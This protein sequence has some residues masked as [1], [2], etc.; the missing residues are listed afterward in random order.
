MKHIKRFKSQACLLYYLDTQRKPQLSQDYRF[1]VE[2]LESKYNNQLNINC[3]HQY[4]EVM[5]VYQIEL[6]SY[7]GIISILHLQ[8][9]LLPKTNSMKERY[10]ICS[11][12]Q[13]WILKQQNYQLGILHNQQRQNKIRQGI[14]NF[15][16]LISQVQSNSGSTKRRL[17]IAQ[18][19]QGKCQ[20]FSFNLNF[21]ML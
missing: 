6:Q 21:C 19:E 10:N 2:L 3:N 15:H 13:S 4:L 8:M 7:Q 5:K 17:R 16:Y 12:I 14:C 18:K 11:L 20:L 9:M 1:K